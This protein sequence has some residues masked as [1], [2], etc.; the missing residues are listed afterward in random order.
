MPEGR[1]IAHSAIKLCTRHVDGLEEVRAIDHND[2]PEE[3]D[4]RFRLEGEMVAGGM[5][6]VYRAVD[7]V[8]GEIVAVKISSSFGSQ[9]GERFQQE[10]TFLAEIAHPAIVRYL[11][12]GRTARGEHY[13]VM[14]WLDGETLEDRLQNGALSLAE[15]FGLARRVSEALVA[16][17]TRGI[18]HRDIKPANIFLP[19]GDLSKVKLLD[20]GIARRLF[21]GVLPRLTQIGTALGT[22]MYMSP[23]QAQG[24]LDVDA[25]ADIFSMGCVLFEC[26]TGTPPFWGESTTATMAK[27]ADGSEIDVSKRCKGLSPRLSRLLGRMLAKQ[28]EDRPASM[29]EVLLELGRITGDLRATGTLPAISSGGTPRGLLTTTGERRLAAVIL[30]STQDHA[31]ERSH[32]DP[33]ATVSDLGTVLARGLVNIEGG[34]GPDGLDVVARAIAPWGARIQRLAKGGLV[35]TLLADGTS[36][37]LDLA[38]QAARC[39]LRLKTARPGSSFALSM[40]HALVDDQQ[41]HLGRLIDSAA[42]LLTHTGAIH[43]SEE[44]RRLLEARFEITAEGDRSRLLFERGLR[45]APRTVLGKEVPCVGR[46][47]EIASLLSAFEGSVEEPCAQV[48]LLTGGPG[49]GKSR[50]AHESLEQVRD[51]GQPFEL[52]VGRGDPMRANV[53]LGFLAQAIRGAAGIGGTEPD[54]TQRKRL[55]AHAGRHLPPDSAHETVAF[56]G[57]IAGIQFS[58]ENL[59][60]LRAARSDGRLMAD[61]TQRA[62]VDW[63]EAETKHRPVLML[64]ED[65]HWSDS[66]SVFYTDVALRELRDKP[67]MVLAL[68][69]PEVDQR[70]SSL[71]RERGVQTIAI[72][73]LGKRAVQE[74]A[75]RILGDKAEARLDWILEQAQGNPFYLEELAR[76]FAEGKDVAEVPS[77]VLGMVQM[78]FDAVGEGAKQVLR[79][80]SIFGRSFRAAGAKALLADLIPEDVDRWI[81]ILIDK[82]ILFARPFG[83]SREHVFRHA[84]HRDAAYALLPPESAAVGHRLAGEFLEQAGERDAIVL[85]D[86]FERGKEAPRAVRW[87]RVA[88]N[89]ALET[90][91]LAAAISRAERGVL[92]GAAGD[93]LSELLIVESESF[94]WQGNY[95]SAE[96][97]V[98][99][100][101]ACV[102]PA[103]ALRAK[104]ALLNCL[105]I[106]G[107]SAEV[108][109]MAVLL[110]QEPQDPS[111]I[112]L[113]LECVLDV[114]AHLSYGG[115]QVLA[116]RALALVERKGDPQD[117]HLA[118]RA[119][120]VRSQLARAEGNLSVASSHQSRS[121][122]LHEKSGNARAACEALGNMAVWLMEV[123]QLEAAEEHAR[124]VL[125]MSETMRLSHF[126]GGVSQ[127]LTNCLAYQGRLDEARA[128]GQRGL[129]WTR[130]RGDRWFLPYVQLYLSMTEYLASDYPAAEALARGALN[131]TVDKPTLRPFGLA[132]F[133]RARL[134]QG[135]VAEGLALAKEAYL[136]IE[137]KSQVE[138]GEATVRLAQAEALVAA[139]RCHE[140][141]VVVSEAMLWLQRRAQTLDDPA[142]RLSFLDRIPEHRRLRELAAE[143]GLA[144]TAEQDGRN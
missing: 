122:Q 53:S 42:V 61:Q 27:V 89:Q 101:Q 28:V 115:N 108:A 45:E 141:V 121:V 41:V 2:L 60:Q 31:G 118:A 24:S 35:V 16:A 69:R 59:P 39:S 74:L 85:A 116:R 104:S 43:V 68:A 13:L 124:R 113:W 88:A 93:D 138:D 19:G 17:H 58:D 14:E 15:T 22:P 142:M 62:W 137:S 6:T 136:A 134:A 36:T 86:H 38:V 40:G 71:W 112:P 91:D 26:L 33:T 11:S 75:R 20:F 127:M 107:K 98:R 77:T 100:V 76:V 52:L 66:P 110:D 10:A 81:E 102:D 32:L 103:L 73:P 114:T 12:H 97:V 82:E 87:L 128:I 7:L 133:A 3:L 131:S 5:G 51:R 95:A 129:A 143:L 23:E 139:G 106:A 78:R 63:L 140:A 120:S 83:N 21:D 8:S 56:L 9:L 80:A 79:A 57:E 34:P 47:R 119:E 67:F 144:K 132:L 50:I 125:A 54:E 1:P 25:R 46:A 126:F 18:I 72:P 135:F 92:L 70:F 130:E 37:P 123:G 96:N 48:I 65:L 44:M 117:A 29:H 111:L 4:G 90:N 49:S 94:Y 30:V 105:G 109:A 99:A 84:L 64:L 55:L